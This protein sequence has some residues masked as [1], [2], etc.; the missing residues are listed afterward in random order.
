M[1]MTVEID[2]ALLERVMA[3]TGART[4]T[5]AIELAL[6][7]MD[8]RGALLRLLD[9]DLGMTPTDWRGAF[10]DAADI[11]T[12]RAAE[13]PGTYGGHTGSR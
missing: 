3:V 11:E 6:R 13:T 5:A 7:E 12:L 8:R 9:D 10:D 2:E 4:K 1:K